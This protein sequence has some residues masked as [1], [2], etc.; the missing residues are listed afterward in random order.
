MKGLFSL[1]FLIF[2]FVYLVFLGCCEAQSGLAESIEVEKDSNDNEI[3]E[4]TF[5]APTLLNVDPRV[6]LLSSAITSACSL[7]NLPADVKNVCTCQS[8]SVL[9]NEEAAPNESN[10]SLR[11]ALSNLKSAVRLVCNEGRL[12]KTVLSGVCACVK[13]FVQ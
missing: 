5:A 2:L 4:K 8:V 11:D 9:G 12:T 3:E 13:I 10:R 1:M 7:E 6:K